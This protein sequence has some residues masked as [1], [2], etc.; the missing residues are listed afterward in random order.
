MK[1]MKNMKLNHIFIWFGIV[2]WWSI[3]A[4]I[5][6]CTNM[7]QVFSLEVTWY[8]DGLNTT[9]KGFYFMIKLQ[10]FFQLAIMSPN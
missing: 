5:V 1:Q 2:L 10:V 7:L 6:K 3:V 4:D 8:G 9:W